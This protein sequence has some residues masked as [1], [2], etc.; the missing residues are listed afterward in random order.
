MS[1]FLLIAL[2]SAFGAV[3]RF[4]LGQRLLRSGFSHP[5]VATLAVNLSGCGLAG[6]LAGFAEPV[7][8]VVSACLVTGFLASY[9]TVSSF[10]LET[11]GMWQS[12]R[13]RLAVAYVLT[14]TVGGL[15]LAWAG[16][17]LGAS[18]VFAT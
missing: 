10:S 4:G 9:T 1:Q 8:S 13:V 6:F 2:G 11:L 14:S 3:V 15:T 17:R 5:V 16:W 7:K 18:G 12:G